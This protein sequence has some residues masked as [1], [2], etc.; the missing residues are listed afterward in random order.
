MISFLDPLCILGPISSC[1]IAYKLFKMEYLNA[2]NKMFLLY[3]SLDMVLGCIDTFY[4]LKLK[5][6]RYI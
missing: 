3:F 6:E 1:I 2:I 4:L 5:N